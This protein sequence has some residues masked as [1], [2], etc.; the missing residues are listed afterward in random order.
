MGSTFPRRCRRCA[1]LPDFSQFPEKPFLKTHYPAPVELPPDV[2]VL[3][4]FGDPVRA[5]LST[6]HNRHTWGHFRYCGYEG[7]E[8]PDIYN[9]DALGY[10]RIFDSWT[11]EHSYPVLALRFER[12]WAYQSL[13][14][15]F[16]ERPLALP[17]FRSRTTEPPR[18]QAEHLRDVYSGL[19]DK[20]SA[21]P[22]LCIHGGRQR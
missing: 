6:L 20:V 3:F 7:D 11:A 8:W 1:F 18:E 4:L 13:V 19:V 10:E 16:I 12:L 21:A 14:E 22:D 5:V 9:E 15:D 17:P 2:R